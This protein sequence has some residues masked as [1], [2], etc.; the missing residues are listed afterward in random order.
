MKLGI[1]YWIVV[2]RFI[3]YSIVNEEN[4]FKPASSVRLSSGIALIFVKRGMDVTCME[5]SDKFDIQHSDSL[6]MTVIVTFMTFC[7]VCHSWSQHLTHDLRITIIYLGTCYNTCTCDT[8]YHM[9]SVID[10][11]WAFPISIRFIEFETSTT[12]S[13]RTSWTA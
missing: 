13:F 9:C 4:I 8:S 12:N 3:I 10:K 1:K 2:T 5:N 6:N 11:I 7:H